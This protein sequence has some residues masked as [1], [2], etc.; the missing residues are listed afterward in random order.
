MVLIIDGF[1]YDVTSYLSEHPGGEDVLKSLNG[2]DAT[3]HFRQANHPQHA[4][5]RRESFLIG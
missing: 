2:K 3:E 5:A 1:V 4:Y